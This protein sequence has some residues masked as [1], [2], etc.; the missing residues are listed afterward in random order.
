MPKSATIVL[1]NS[2]T[3]TYQTHIF[4]LRLYIGPSFFSKK[5]K[6]FTYELRHPSYTH[7]WGSIAILGVVNDR[8]GKKAAMKESRSYGKSAP[9]I[10]NTT[11][12]HPIILIYR[13]DDT[14]LTNIIV[15]VV[16]TT[17]IFY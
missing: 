7:S 17:S 10:R 13:S 12:P 1:G 5:K 4:S 9:C 8:N 14:R 3:G 6:K 2:E 11:P 16:N 15:M